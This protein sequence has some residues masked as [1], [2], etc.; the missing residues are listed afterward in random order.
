MDRNTVTGII[1]IAII[2]IGYSILTSPSEEE[3]QAVRHKRDSILY[4]EDSIARVKAIAAEAAKAKDEIITPDTDS[5][6]TDS[7]KVINQ[8]NELQQKYGIF[9]G[10][11]QGEEKFVILENDLMKIR[12]SAKGGRPYSV[13]LKDYKSFDSTQVR[14]FDGDSTVF[15]LL[16]PTGNNARTVRT[17]DFYFELEEDAEIFDATTTE[18]TVKLRL[19][20]SEYQYVEYAY[21]LRPGSHTLD[22][23]INFVGMDDIISMNTNYLMFKWQYDVPRTE[24]G[25]DWEADNATIY[26]KFLDDEVDY[27]TERSDTQEERLNANVKWIAFKDHFFS[28]ALIA[29]NHLLDPYVKYTRTDHSPTHI[30]NCMADISLPFSSQTKQIPLNFYFGPNHYSTLEDL[31]IVKDDNLELEALVPLGWG[32]FGWVNQWLIIPL[33]Q[34]LGSFLTNYGLIILLLTVAIKML[35][36]P[37]TYKSYLSTAKMRVLKPQIDELNAKIPKDKAMERQQAT[38]GL[39]RK[40]G[41][42]PMGGCLP[43]LLQMPILIAMYRFFPASIELRQKGFLW[44]DDLSTYDSILDL[45]FEIPWYGDHVSLFT[46]LM[47]ISM[48]ATTKMNSGQM[49][50]SSSSMPGMKMMMYMMPVMMLFWFNNYSAGLSYYFFLSNMITFGQTVMIRRFVNDDEVLKKIKENK[51]KPVKK[52]KFQQRLEDMAKQRGYQPPKKKK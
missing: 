22:F 39:Y 8:Q 46:L 16:F 38:M 11:V 18:R 25:R 2:L 47:A 43:M 40:A 17:D 12:L 44:A 41:V 30:M 45:P 33:F 31:T 26:Y 42:N 19:K 29:D 51:K 28:S 9:A 10:A 37:L 32:I 20:A 15:T 7:A 4:T 1:L 14:L 52:S 23:D 50:A 49:N 5:L 48:M 3:L 35:L 36:F 34:L 27:L 21:T 24:K 13:E 6:Q